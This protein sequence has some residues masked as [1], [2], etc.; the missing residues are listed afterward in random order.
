ML[1]VPPSYWEGL[2]L[3]HRWRHPLTPQIHFVVIV[4]FCL[5]WAMGLFVTLRPWLASSLWRRSYFNFPAYF[6]VLFTRQ[7]GW[8]CTLHTQGMEF[9]S[10][11]IGVQPHNRLPH[12]G[13]GGQ[14]QSGFSQRTHCLCF[15]VPLS[16][17]SSYLA[18][19]PGTVAVII[20]SALF[21]T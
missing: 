19:D 14:T 18:Y 15:L 12:R 6:F 9:K 21:R 3:S 17:W 8:S 20:C 16:I 10:C 7:P 1:A 2:S 4:T 11:C 13:R 5:R